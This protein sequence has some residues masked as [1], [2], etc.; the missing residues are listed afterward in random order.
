ML[1]LID[2]ASFKNRCPAGAHVVVDSTFSPPP[3]QFC[4]ANGRFWK[5]REIIYVDIL[6]SFLIVLGADMVMHSSTKFLG[7]HSDL[8]GGVLV[9]KQQE[10]AKKVWVSLGKYFFFSSKKQFYIGCVLN[11]F[12]LA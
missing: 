3:L 5:R 4:L 11:W 12:D 8:L 9:V 1:C 10:M 7:G 2:I 6:L